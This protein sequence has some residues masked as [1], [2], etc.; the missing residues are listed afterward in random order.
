MIVC[1]I[2]CACA[3]NRLL[4]IYFF[5]ARFLSRTARPACPV[6]EDGEVARRNHLAVPP[7]SVVS[8]CFGCCKVSFECRGKCLADKLFNCHQTMTGLAG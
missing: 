6:M 8:T 3:K 5:G 2:F 4:F 1:I 7:R